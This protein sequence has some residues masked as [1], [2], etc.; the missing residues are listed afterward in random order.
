M[1]VL[2]TPQ[3]GSP[4]LVISP[5]PLAPSIPTAS[6]TVQ[7]T[8][9]VGTG[10][11]IAGGVLNANVTSVAGRIGAIT[12]SAA[13]I[14]GLGTM[15]TQSAG[16]VAITGGTIL[17][18][19]KLVLTETSPFPQSGGVAFDSTTLTY[20]IGNTLPT[21]AGVASYDIAQT[22]NGPYSTGPGAHIVG[23][24][25]AAYHNGVAAPGDPTS[26]TIDLLVAGEF[27]A[28]VPSATGRV[29]RLTM[30]LP[31]LGNHDGWAGDVLWIDPLWTGTTG[32]IDGTFAIYYAPGD[33]L[34]PGNYSGG[35]WLMMSPN[36]A[37][38]VRIAGKYFSGV[39]QQL[40][41]APTAGSAHLNWRVGLAPTTP[42]GK[43]SGLRTATAVVPLYL[44]N[45]EPISTVAI[46]IIDPVSGGTVNVQLYRLY[47]RGLYGLGG[48]ATFPATGISFNAS[49]AGE[50]IAFRPTT[51]YPAGA[52][53]ICITASDDAIGILAHTEASILGYFGVDGIN[54][55]TAGAI[56]ME[57]FVCGTPF[58]GTIGTTAW[59]GSNT[60][61]QVAGALSGTVGVQF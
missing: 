42:T 5:I 29:N 11:A 53:A 17:G 4:Q 3:D 10:L 45:D 32:R 36:P 6:P 37:L 48:D 33:A 41:P 12:L 26:A 35:K 49:A 25:I 58:S 61:V 51:S 13:D 21:G 59:P 52:Y 57:Q 2:I 43:V 38:D 18:V 23:R 27:I 31:K 55:L 8:V 60:I 19:S 14:G 46:N 9:K 16:A 24:Q 28:S 15:A 20:T 7:G 30:M 39:N 47:N 50:Q 56:A 22:D 40:A 34:P 44:P 1:K 54:N